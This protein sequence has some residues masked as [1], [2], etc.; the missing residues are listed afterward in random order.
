MATKLVIS[1]IIE[2]RGP[3]AEAVISSPV[4]PEDV[5]VCFATPGM[6]EKEITSSRG[7]LGLLP[8]TFCGLAVELEGADACKSRPNVLSA[9]DTDGGFGLESVLSIPRSV[10]SVTNKLCHQWNGVRFLAIVVERIKARRR[11]L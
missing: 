8:I 3:R 4:S 10:R 11:I 6:P 9:H 1:A 7:A 5:E 2:Y